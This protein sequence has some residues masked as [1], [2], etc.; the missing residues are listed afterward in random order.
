MNKRFTTRAL[1]ILLSVVLLAGILPGAALAN[2]LPTELSNPIL[3]GSIESEA[4]PANVPGGTPGTGH[5]EFPR[6]IAEIEIFI[7][8]GA[9]AGGDGSYEYPFNTLEAINGDL[10]QP[11]THFLIKAGSFFNNVRIVAPRSGEEGRVIVIDMYGDGPKPVFSGGSG[12]GN[13]IT[14]NQSYWEFRN[15]NLTWWDGVTFDGTSGNRTAF[16]AQGGNVALPSVVGGPVSGGRDHLFIIDCDIFNI[17]SNKSNTHGAGANIQ[18][19]WR[20]LVIAGNTFVGISR[21]AIRIGNNGAARWTNTT[22]PH[23]ANGG[24]ERFKMLDPLVRNN[25]FDRIGGDILIND[26]TFGLV[27]EYNTAFRGTHDLPQTPTGSNPNENMFSAGIWGWE[28]SNALF[29][30][31]EVAFM[32]DGGVGD[33]SAFDFDSNCTGFTVYQFNYTHHNAG[34][35][36]LYCPAGRSTG[37]RVDG[38]IQDTRI[39]RYNISAFESIST[40]PSG[41]SELTFVYNNVYYRSTPGRTTAQMTQNWDVNLYESSSPPEHDWD[42]WTVLPLG[43][44]QNTMFGNYVFNNIF[45]RVE[46][47][48]LNDATSHTHGDT[49]GRN[50]VIHHLFQNNL[51]YETPVYFASNLTTR[52][53]EGQL[54]TDAAGLVR[55]NV[56]ANPKFLGAID[57]RDARGFGMTEAVRIAFDSPARDIGVTVEEMLDI[58]KIDMDRANA[59]AT[60]PNRWY[61][62]FNHINQLAFDTSLPG[63]VAETTDF[64]GTPL[65]YNT[66]FAGVSAAEVTAQPIILSLDINPRRIEME[67]NEDLSDFYVEVTVT[68]EHLT[69]DERLT[70]FGKD[71]DFVNGI[72]ISV[73]LADPSFNITMFSRNFATVYSSDS[74][75]AGLMKLDWL[76]VFQ[77]D[78]PAEE[79]PPPGLFLNYRDDINLGVVSIRSAY[80]VGD[81]GDDLYFVLAMSAGIAPKLGTDIARI[82]GALPI[83]I[84]EE[85]ENVPHEDFWLRVYAV[86]SDGEITGFDSAQVRW[87]NIGT[88]IHRES[89]GRVVGTG[90]FVPIGEESWSEYR[91]GIDMQR[92]SGSGRVDVYFHHLGTG[93]GAASSWWMIPIALA[94]G[95]GWIDLNWRDGEGNTGTASATSSGWWT[96]AFEAWQDNL[97][98]QIVASAG[99]RGAASDGWA[100]NR[101]QHGIQFRVEPNGTPRDSYGSRTF[102]F[103][104]GDGG[105]DKGNYGGFNRVINTAGKTGFT[106]ASGLTVDI[107]NWSIHED[108][109]NTYA[110]RT[111]LVEVEIINTDGVLS[112]SVLPE[113]ATIQFEWSIEDPIAGSLILGTGTTFT[114]PTLGAGEEV[115][116][117]LTVAGTGAYAGTVTDSITISISEECEECEEYPCECPKLC[118]ECEEYPCEC[119][120]LCE[121]GHTWGPWVVTT[122][123]QIGVPGVETRTCPVC[124]ESETRPI[125]ALPQPPPPPPPYEECDDCG[126]YPCDCDEAPTRRWY[127]PLPQNRFADVE[128][129]PFWQN[130]PVSWADRNGI[131]QG[132]AGTTPPEFRPNRPLTR[133]MFATFMHRIADMPEAEAASDFVD[134]DRVNTWAVDTVNWAAEIGVI[135]GFTDNTF[136]PQVNITREQMALMLFRYAGII[137]AD[138]EFTSVAFD[139]FPDRGRVNDWAA[140][141]MRWATHHGIITG[142]RGNIAPRS[143]ATRAETVTMLQ[144]FVD[145]FDVPPPSWVNYTD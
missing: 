113:G 139:R 35:Q 30:H 91:M 63:N 60:G 92:Y 101:N 67:Y 144:R 133:E 87:S 118:D 100:G 42:D 83:S 107:F 15:L 93:I 21:T 19:V 6:P 22:G 124:G 65:E 137:E 8:S 94:P 3:Y 18:G 145:T 28:A 4:F 78:E 73:N 123:P 97:H 7:D 59:A 70:V 17:D 74:Q 112:A 48:T 31:N 1:A 64:F 9:P 71:V 41:T 90:Q 132:I 143:N 95:G 110:S 23:F 33:R 52:V 84:G 2:V 99:N 43:H 127:P 77:H 129:R 135:E 11:G 76:G 142:Q 106:V 47:L 45:Y 115:E 46:R 12:T 117:I 128:G 5:L 111:Q 130:D 40:G 26:Y 121:D 105:A 88:T 39:V 122:P 85:L 126:E 53:P 57:T 20:D 32:R 81:V 114:M 141:A 44:P 24:D 55:N 138:T 50:Y 82:N 120:E 134:S 66:H 10:A 62:D 75:N 79:P 136:R 102:S 104:G 13:L 116:F 98:F 69:G 49:P 58:I 14:V 140:D 131:T 56:I 125:P 119:P 109:E 86:N 61:L 51:L 72:P 29:Q 16:Q 96:D 89:P 54:T 36:M 80:Q 34:G 68:G 25:F 37:P 103:W 108:V 27:F 38:F